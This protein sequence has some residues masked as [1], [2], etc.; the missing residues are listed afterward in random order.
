MEEPIYKSDVF[1]NIDHKLHRKKLC[2]PG[3][4]GIGIIDLCHHCRRTSVS[5]RKVIYLNGITNQN[6][7]CGF[8]STYGRQ[9][10]PSKIQASSQEIY[11]Y[12]FHVLKRNQFIFSIE[13]NQV[14][15]KRQKLCSANEKSLS[16]PAH[17]L[18]ELIFRKLLIRIKC[19]IIAKNSSKLKFVDN[20]WMSNDGI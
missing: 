14:D 16:I 9:T 17:Y 5:R 11:G 20:L 19:S 6:H 13:Y 10:T 18:H 7:C 1:I 3:L 15:N 4:I 8:R 2:F 12:A